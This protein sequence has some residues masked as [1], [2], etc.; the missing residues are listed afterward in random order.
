MNGLIN[1]EVDTTIANF[2]KAAKMTKSSADTVL[3]HEKPQII[4]TL[5]HQQKLKCKT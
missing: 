1:P 2:Q 4:E 3:F 5:T